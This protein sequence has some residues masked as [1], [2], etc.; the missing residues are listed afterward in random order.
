MLH[1]LHR[2][3]REPTALLSNGELYFL[4]LNF[5]LTIM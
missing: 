2:L 5:K 4:S 3:P 1:N